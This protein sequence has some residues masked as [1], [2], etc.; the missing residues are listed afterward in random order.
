M[1]S[2]PDLEPGGSLDL[3]AAEL[4]SDGADLQALLGALAARLED[5]LPRMVSVKRRKVGGFL[6]K[7]TE[8]QAIALNVG[9]TRFELVR[10]PGGVDCTRHAVVRGITLRREQRTLAE[11]LDEVVAAVGHTA[12]VGEQARIALEALVR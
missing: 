11:W 1:T 9:D 3:A 8:V 2:D 7:E 4:R 12:N 6:S 10:T 5:A